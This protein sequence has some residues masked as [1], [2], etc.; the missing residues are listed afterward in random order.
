[1][2]TFALAA[3][4]MDYLWCYETQ[5]NFFFSFSLSVLLTTAKMLFPTGCLWT[6]FSYDQP[7]KFLDLADFKLTLR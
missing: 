5:D 1:M 3:E 7:T 2:I 4:F 6:H